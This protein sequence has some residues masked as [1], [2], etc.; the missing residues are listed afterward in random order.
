MTVAEVE[1]VSPPH[2]VLAADEFENREEEEEL[3]N[4]ELDDTV[5]TQNEN[6]PTETL[7]DQFLVVTMNFNAFERNSI[8]GY[9]MAQLR[10]IVGRFYS[11]VFNGMNLLGAHAVGL[12]YDR[13]TESPTLSCA[14]DLPHDPTVLLKYAKDARF[15]GKT[16]RVVFHV[17]FLSSI[18][19][20]HLKRAYYPEIGRVG[21]LTMS[22]LKI[23]HMV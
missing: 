10:D 17:R 21:R 19:V 22:L 7:F 14:A 16:E 2:T 12:P 18:P 5:T 23:W 15:N 11:V 8:T 9:P 20:V 13:T 4:L 1:K 3:L 6:I